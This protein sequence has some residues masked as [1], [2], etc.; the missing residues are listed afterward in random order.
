MA[1]ST[2]RSLSYSHASAEDDGEESNVSRSRSGDDRDQRQQARKA[3]QPDP[4]EKKEYLETA[5]R[6]RKLYDEKIRRQQGQRQDGEAGT[7]PTPF[8][9]ASRSPSVSHR[10][11]IPETFR[12]DTPPAPS[13]RL[14]PTPSSS[15][16]PPSTP[17]TLL[18]HTCG[19]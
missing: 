15:P 14:R 18:I 6:E 19:F 17:S 13:G 16:R 5:S 8:Y 9:P 11:A 10:G 2:G 1:S 3:M 12:I 4:K 7:R